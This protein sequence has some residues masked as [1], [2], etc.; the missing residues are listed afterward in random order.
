VKNTEQQRNWIS[1]MRLRAASAVLVA[2]A[3]PMLAVVTAQSA[4]GQT[5]TSLFSFDGTDGYAPQASLVQATNGNLYGTT[6]V[7]GANEDCTFYAVTTG[8]GTVFTITPSGTLTSLY[9][10]CAQPG[11][12]DGETPTGALI[13]A[14]NGDLY[15]TSG[16]GASGYGTVYRITLSGTLTT[17]HSF[18]STDGSYPSAGL[19]QDTNGDFYGV[20]SY[21]GAYGQGTVFKIT[22]GGALTTLYSFCSQ[23]GCPDG[24]GPVGPLVQA[25][26]GSFYGATVFGGNSTACTSGCGTVFKITTGGALTTLHSFEYTDGKNPNAGLVQATNGAFY[27][28]TFYGGAYN[29]PYGYGTVFKITPSGTLTTLVSFD[30]TDGIWPTAGLVQGTDG[31]LYGETQLGGINGV[32]GTIFKMTPSGTL[33]TLYNFCS[34]SDCKD[35]YGPLAAPTQDTNGTFYGTTWLGGASSTC[36]GC[37][38]GGGNGTVFSLSVGLR[39]FVETQT[40]SGKVGAAVKILGTNLTGATSVT[41]N[42][43]AATF[44][45]VSKSEIT[46]TVPEGATTGTVEVTTPRGT[47]K[48]NTKFRVTP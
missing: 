14:T 36:E 4:Q 28:T 19:V 34:Q 1:R 12:T 6:Q 24:S 39:Q 38:S 48:S 46:T 31:N 35:G 41:F 5:F 11:C 13:Q 44:T 9:S 23:S 25:A 10:F 29:S 33:T 16:G 17:L 45:V 32:G 7:G 20:T 3:V 26:N 2:A 47:L 42:G 18:D 27:G 8:C 15:G 30:D 40:T 43:T 22:P 37:V 21:G